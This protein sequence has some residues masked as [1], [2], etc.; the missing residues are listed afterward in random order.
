V[1]IV[2]ATRSSPEL[3][4]GASPRA[5][6]HLVRAARASAALERRDFVTPDDIRALAPFVLAHRLL[7]TVEA[8]MGGR[9]VER[10]LDQVLS[11]VPAPGGG[12]RS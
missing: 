7:P 3:V 12:W 5:T 8:T 6:L 11:A 10:V 4:L 2:A 1:A 9:S